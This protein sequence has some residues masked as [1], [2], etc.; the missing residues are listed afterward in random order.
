[1]A[2]AQRMRASR[3][4]LA[5]RAARKDLDDFDAAAAAQGTTLAAAL[6]GRADGTLSYADAEAQCAARAAHATAAAAADARLRQSGALPATPPAPPLPPWRRQRAPSPPAAA[7]TAAAAAMTADVSLPATD[8]RPSLSVGASADGDGADDESSDE[9]DEGA[10]VEAAASSAEATAAAAAVVSAE[11]ALSGLPPG[12]EPRRV[13]V[14]HT[15]ALGA[16][17]PLAPLHEATL[18]GAA[19]A[20]ITADANGVPG[21]AVHRVTGRVLSRRRTATVCSLLI[22][23]RLMCQ[24]RPLYVHGQLVRLKSHVPLMRALDCDALPVVHASLALLR[25]QVRFLG[26]WKRQSMRTVTAIYRHA[27]AGSGGSSVVGGCNIGGGGGSSGGVDGAA[28]SN[29]SSFSASAVADDPEWVETPSLMRVLRNM[30]L[31]TAQAP[32]PAAD[33][34]A[35]EAVR[36]DAAAA[37]EAA[38]LAAAIAAGERA[39]RRRELAR[40]LASGASIAELLK[41]G[42]DGRCRRNGG[43]IFSRREDED[44]GNG[45]DGAG[46]AGGAAHAPLETASAGAATASAAAAA[47]ADSSASA[48]ATDAELGGGRGGGGGVN[49]GSAE[50]GKYAAVLHRGPLRSG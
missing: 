3:S 1:M 5:L 35:A 25:L 48:G 34:A 46:G 40:R 39:E 4:Q 31:S 2:V 26:V 7:A 41:A 23:L 47:A 38:E 13:G 21:A 11:F 16:G 37:V 22:A 33:A 49:S 32:A 12:V 17:L 27:F 9:D 24:G 36:A 8:P 19:A 50:A 42:A 30:A 29:A 20:L 18:A 44:G 6:F 14:A 28:G 43:S 15:L 10:E 45:E